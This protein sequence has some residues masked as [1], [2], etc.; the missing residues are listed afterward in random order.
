MIVILSPAKSLDYESKL[1]FEESSELLLGE[2]AAYLAGKLKKFSSR[3]L[4]QMMDISSDLAELNARRFQEFDPSF[5]TSVS[6]QAI[7]AFNGDVYQGLDA[8]T[9]SKIQIDY[10][11]RHLRILSGLYGWLRPLDLMQ[12]YRLEMGTSWSVTPKKTSLY[13]YWD[14]ELTGLLQEDM[15]ATDSEYVLNLAS[16][17]YSKA[18]KFNILECTV[19]APEFLEE[20]GGDYKMISFF[21]KKA[22]GLMARF[23]IQNK[24]TDH[25]ALKNFDSEGYVFSERLSD[26]GTNKWVYTR[27]SKNQ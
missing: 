17:E 2:N 13:K 16:Q 25:T 7:Y 27:K 15:E 14:Q 12:P 26:I 20:R 5:S 24:I 8:Y 10:A 3:K 21:A 22:R 6:R 4:S 19:I 1:P 23:V 9:L 18:L 11:Q